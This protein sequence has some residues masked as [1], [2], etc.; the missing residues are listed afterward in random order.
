LK[1]TSSALKYQFTGKHEKLSKA[2]SAMTIRFFILQAHYRSTL[3]FG[4]DA[5]QAAEKGFN[6]LM[7]AIRTLNELEAG[8]ESSFD[9]E[10]LE[11]KCYNAINDDFNTPILLA[12]L[13]EGVKII[14]S[15]KDGNVQLNNIDLKKMK[16]IFQ[17]FAVNILGLK[18][19]NNHEE[20]NLTN[21]VMD[22]ILQLRKN[23][24][25]NQDFNTADLIR[26]EL[27]KK[28]IQIKDS[29]DGSSWSIKKQ[30]T[31]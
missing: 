11:R 7:E 2:Y 23:A 21:E 22:L 8:Q 5:L 15:V 28:G 29:R 13:F 1:A 18:L 20:N 31:F 4:N 16:S 24:K 12:N 30:S 19:V 3:D 9:V 17:I 6:K 14:N 10:A 25:K 27:D 26:N